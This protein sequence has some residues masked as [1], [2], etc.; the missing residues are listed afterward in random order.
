MVMVVEVRIPRKRIFHVTVLSD[1]PHRDDQNQLLACN[2][3]PSVPYCTTS[4]KV[5]ITLNSSVVLYR[6]AL[7]H[8]TDAQ[9]D[10]GHTNFSPT[11]LLPFSIAYITRLHSSLL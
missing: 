2:Y 6:C 8:V 7:V 1:F 10:V 5:Q 11:L 9:L 4:R 3:L